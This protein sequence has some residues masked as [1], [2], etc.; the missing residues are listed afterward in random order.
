ME[1]LSDEKPSRS[2]EP[3]VHP[4]APVLDIT[5]GPMKLVN[6]HPTTTHHCQNLGRSLFLKRSRHYYGHQYSRRNSA[7]H[8]NASSSCGK[9]TSSN[10]ERL[11]FKLASQ[12]KSESRRYAE[13]RDKIFSRPERIRSSS[14][15]VDAVSPDAAEMVCGVCQKP[16]KRKLFLLGNSLSSNELSIVAVLVC[17][18]AYHAE[19]LEQKT[20]FDERRD[21]PC[22]LCA[23]LLLQDD[24]C[25]G[26]E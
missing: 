4:L 1:L 3:G 10:D 26:Q 16:L 5:D 6:A 11:S 21:P 14:S 19:C 17:G 12:S 8:A 25:K 18:H 20:S 24:D 2:G 9:N 22:P 15:V 23:G 13:F 7:N